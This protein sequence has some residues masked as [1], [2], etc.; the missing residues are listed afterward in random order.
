MVVDVKVELEVVCGFEMS[1]ART[2][3]PRIS[4]A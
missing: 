4:S 2:L 1:C 3:L